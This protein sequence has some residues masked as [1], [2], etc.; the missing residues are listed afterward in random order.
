MMMRRLATLIAACVLLAVT[1]VLRSGAGDATGSRALT[2]LRDPSTAPLP[3]PSGFSPAKAARFRAMDWLRQR[4]ATIPA[5]APS[6]SSTAA[7]LTGG[8]IGLH[9]GGPFTPAQFLGTN[10][11]NGRVGGRWLVVQ[12]GGVPL[13]GSASMPHGPA[14]AAHLKAAVFVYSRS[15]RPDSSASPRVFGVIRAPRNP[16]GELVVESVKGKSISLSLLGS[17]RVYRFNVATLRFL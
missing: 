17:R 14:S 5:S 4:A 12:A 15:T 2:A 8:I 9:D 7:A 13:L 10:L 11:W 16:T 1:L 6:G 3:V